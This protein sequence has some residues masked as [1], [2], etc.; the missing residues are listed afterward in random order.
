MPKVTHVS[1]DEH[2]GKV[3][4]SK[5][6]HIAQS[7]TQRGGF[8]SMDTVL[9]RRENEYWKIQVD[10]FQSWMLGFNKFVGEWKTTKV[11]QNKIHIEYTYHL[12]ANNMFLYP[13]NW[14]FV[15]LFWKNYMNQVVEN[16]RKMVQ[17]KEPDLN[18]F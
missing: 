17:D 12:Y 7:L 3:G 5:K 4:G 18:S 2:W 15:R 11:T 6:I 9:E 14:L 16:I 10:N 13:L 1:D 8:G